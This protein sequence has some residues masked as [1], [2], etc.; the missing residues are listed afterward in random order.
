MYTKS[1][2]MADNIKFPPKT[3]GHLSNTEGLQS[4][5][6]SLVGMPFRLTGAPRTDGSNLRKLISNA[7]EKAGLPAIADA[8]SY[9]IMPP[10]KK[11]VPKMLAELIDSYL[12][13]SGDS[14]NLQVWNRIPN[15]ESVLVE[16]SDESDPLR[17]C[18]VR[19]V[20]AKID[21]ENS[22]ID[23]IA[24]LS[25]EY[26]EKKWGK[27]GK[28]TIKHQLLISNIIRGK[29]VRSAERMAFAVDTERGKSFSTGQFILPASGLHDPI[30]PS[31]LFSIELIRDRV[32][33]E[34]IGRKIN[35]GDTKTR[36]QALEKMVAE[37]LGYNMEPTTGLVGGYP[38]IPNQLLEVKVQDAQTIDLGKYTPE[39][40]EIVV[41]GLGLTT[42]DV[43]Y[44]IA[45][46]NPATNIIEGVVLMPGAELG[47]R[48][49]YVSDTSYKCQRSI[50]MA[51]FVGIKG[52]CA[53]N[54]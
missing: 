50:P 22:K 29:I 2:T 39:I 33:T 18:D 38:D 19:L 24:I 35:A 31:R 17:N 9:S 1:K 15:S 27:F 54:P 16:F 44:L 51:F 49:T 28:P 13:T 30:D 45:L 26:I 52:Q 53:V 14:Y 7:L 41:E 11:G 36:G 47:R 25:P 8:E 5:L 40:D 42:Q 48:Y 10:R 6:G 34:L 21:I 32:A 46:T 12:V 20:L 3:K 37:L 43:R 4:T 23:S